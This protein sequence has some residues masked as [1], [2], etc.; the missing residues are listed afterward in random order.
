MT[1]RNNRAEEARALTEAT[2]PL[3]FGDDFTPAKH[4]SITS[5]QVSRESPRFI[6]TIKLERKKGR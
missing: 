2:I 5:V 1:V 3:L 4:S 6:V